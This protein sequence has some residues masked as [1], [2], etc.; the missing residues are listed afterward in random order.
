MPTD[1]GVVYRIGQSASCIS[2]I[3]FVILSRFFRN[4]NS[5]AVH[6]PKKLGFVSAAQKLEVRPVGNTA[7]LRRLAMAAAENE[8]V[9]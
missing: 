8:V 6:L 7:V 4:G 9:F 5:L 3:F 1:R 2:G